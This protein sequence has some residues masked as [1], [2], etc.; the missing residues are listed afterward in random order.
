VLLLT[1]SSKGK[2][3]KKRTPKKER[4][5]LDSTSVEGMEAALVI[6]AYKLVGEQIRKKTVSSQV[7]T[8]FLKTSSSRDILEKKKLKGEIS[9]LDAKV[10]SIK[11]TKDSKAMYEAAIESLK[12]YGSANIS[13]SIQE[14]D[15]DD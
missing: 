12:K 5:F 7:L 8:H 15:P 2:V 10:D 14:V 11:A 1:N 6:E 3:P 13:S 9:L 4:T